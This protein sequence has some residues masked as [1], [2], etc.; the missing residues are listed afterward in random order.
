M[1]TMPSIFGKILSF[2]RRKGN[3]K[4]R[5]VSN[6]IEF[7]KRVGEKKIKCEACEHFV[8]FRNE[9]NKFINTIA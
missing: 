1:V 3:F 8:C 5:S 9:F 2:T 4:I 6:F 7:I